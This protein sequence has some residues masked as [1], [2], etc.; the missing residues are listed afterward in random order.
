M[1][2]YKAISLGLS[3]LRNE[4]GSSFY[5]FLGLAIIAAIVVAVILGDWK[6]VGKKPPASNY[7][8][9]MAALKNGAYDDALKFF[10]EEIKNNPNSG[11]GYIGRS[12]AE[13]A[14][15]NVEQAEK[16]IQVALK[17]APNNQ[18][19]LTQSGLIK[20]IQ[21]N[22]AEALQD[23][24][25]AAK[26]AQ[27][28]WVYA[29]I[30]D[31]QYRQGN[32]KDALEK[33]N[34]AIAK[35]NNYADAYRLRA[36]I[37]NKSGKCEEAAKDIAKAGELDPKS[38]FTKQDQAWFLLTCQ[39]EQLQNPQRAMELA[40][41]AE[42]M[43]GGKDGLVLETVAEAFF[44][45]GDSLKAIEYQKKAIEVGSKKCPDQSCLK[46]MQQRLQKYEMAS[47]LEQRIDYD[48]LANEGDVR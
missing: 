38:A 45:T 39:N 11:L 8:Q 6:S 42:S 30:A 5:T 19:A 41:E 36:W 43:S 14:K 4:R 35:N 47:R 26:T 37:Y 16:D 12:K 13:L 34:M 24:N 15:G 28:P 27:S 23:F 7:Q 9:G 48:I 21:K 17:K 1:K 3:G 33:V 29:Q 44:R 2:G 40:K 18:A 22:Y 32:V 25:K 31:I 10:S 46:E 20:K